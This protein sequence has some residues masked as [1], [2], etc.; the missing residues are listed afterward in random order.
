ML[1][2]QMTNVTGKDIA[3]QIQ[4][5][6]TLDELSVES[7]ENQIDSSMESMMLSVGKQLSKKCILNLKKA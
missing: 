6:L 5:T 4:N 7:D 3:S 2:A 1:A